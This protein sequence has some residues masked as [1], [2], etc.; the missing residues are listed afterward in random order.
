MKKDYTIKLAK[1]N[2]M[3]LAEYLSTASERFV[4]ME[5]GEPW[6]YGSD[7]TPIVY[8]SKEKATEDVAECGSDVALVVSEQYLLEDMEGKAA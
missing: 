6:C 8:P 2:G 1:E 7:G 3:S 4:V 5:N